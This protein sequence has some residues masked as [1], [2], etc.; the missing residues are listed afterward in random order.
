VAQAFLALL[1]VSALWLELPPVT[2][3]RPQ[4]LL[5]QHIAATVVLRHLALA[6]VLLKAEL[7]I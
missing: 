5:V 7:S 6:K 1:A 4:L 2:E 3:V